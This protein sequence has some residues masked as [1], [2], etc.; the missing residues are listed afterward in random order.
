MEVYGLRMR[1]SWFR[2]AGGVVKL[3]AVEEF[4]MAPGKRC[5]KRAARRRA[6]SIKVQHPF[7]LKVHL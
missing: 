4:L 1:A 5:H 2:E 7:A 6:S 3:C